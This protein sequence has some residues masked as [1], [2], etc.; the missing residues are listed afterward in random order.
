MK[1]C[2]SPPG[3]V[4]ENGGLPDLKHEELALLLGLGERLV[5]E[6]D[7][8]TVLS[9]VAESACQVVQAETLVVPIVDPDKQTFTYRAGSGKYAEMI[10]GK[11]FP[12]HEG[13]CGW[14][15]EQQRPLLFGEGGTFDLDLNAR[16]QSGMASSLLVPLICRGVIT[17]GLSA[18][19][20]QGGGA[21]NERDLAVLTLFANQASIA[22]DNA[23]LFKTLDSQ[24]ANLEERV[25]QRTADLARANK[26]LEAFSYSVSHDLRAPLR[27]I[28]GFSR[29]LEEDYR[30]RLDDEGCRLLHVVRTN[31]QRMGDLID[32]I[33]EFSRMGRLDLATR[34]VDMDGLAR[35]VANELQAAAAGR[36][37]NFAIH[38]LP[39]T[40]GDTAMIRQVLVN[41]LA[42]AV[43][44]TRARSP[45]VVEVGGSA[46]EEENVYYVKDNG[47]GFD[48]QYVD[49]LFGVFERLHARE[50]FDGT[51]IGLAIVKRIIERHGGRVWAEARVD[52]GATFHFSL[53]HRMTQ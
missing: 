25:R 21:F 37:L 30:D 41:L 51:G 18:M 15:I 4:S 48:M 14:V 20:K 9:L 31:A 44:F 2:P 17:G 27:A 23:R 11:A 45:A 52:A 38:Q 16:W 42:N 19:G 24:N 34:E 53:P 8:E 10:V 29:M 46:G 50:Q 1:P 43:K 32:D 47:A 7:L 36:D 3:A 6:L 26:E 40:H 13:A 12:I 5:A 49:K 39:P 35:E 33:L 22:I 28:D